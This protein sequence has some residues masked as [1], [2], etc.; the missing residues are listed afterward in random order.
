MVAPGGH[1]IKVKGLK[2]SRFIYVHRFLFVNAH[3]HSVIFGSHP[4]WAAGKC[5]SRELESA[6]SGRRAKFSVES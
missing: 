6:D 5:A 4:D 2:Q 1:V 3:S